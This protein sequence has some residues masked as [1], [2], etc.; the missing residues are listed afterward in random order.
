MADA[1]VIIKA[2]LK[3]EDLTRKI[4]K[5]VQDV[6]N[7]FKD[8]ANKVDASI[9]KVANSLGNFKTIAQTNVREIKDAFQQLGTTFDQFARAMERAAAAASGAGRGRGG[10]GGS[11]GTGVAAPNF[12]NAETLGELKQLIRE[13]QKYIDTLKLGTDE[14]KSQLEVLRKQQEVVKKASSTRLENRNRAIN[15]QLGDINSI[16]P[17]DVSQAESKLQRLKT[18]LGNMERA[19][20]RLGMRKFDFLP[21]STWNRI[22][23]SITRTERQL[24][25]LQDQAAKPIMPKDM[26]GVMGMS[27]KTL[28]QIALKMKAITQLRAQTP[29]GSADISRLNAEYARLSKLQTEIIGKNATLVES[30]NALGRAF[31]YIKNRLAFMLTVGAFTGFVRQLYEIRGQYELL[32]R[33]LGVLLNSFSKGSQIF[34]ELNEMAIKSPFTLIELGTA[35]KQLTAYNFKAN[36]VVD[37]TRR[38]ADISSALGVPM[39]RLV[40]NLGQI[41]AQTVLTARDAR[42][43]ANAGLAIVP[44]LAKHYTE[45]EGKVVSTA[46]VFDRMKKKAVSYNDVMSVLY[47]VTD[48]GGKFFDFQAKQAGTLKVQLANLNLAWNNMLNDMGKANQSLLSWPVQGLRDMFLHWKDISTAIEI[49]LKGLAAY[50]IAQFAIT[51]L[52]GTTNTAMVFSAQA[53]ARANVT[54]LRR[55][56]LTRQLTNEEQIEL[57]RNKLLMSSKKAMTQ[58]DYENVLA[59][60]KLSKAQATQL[61]TTQKTNM[62]LKEAL[63][64]TGTLTR[65]ELNN[66]AVTN[67]WSLAWNRLTITIANVARTIKS[68][69]FNIPTLIMSALAIGLEIKATFNEASDAIEEFNKDLAT[70]AKESNES[71]S[72]FLNDYQKTNDSLYKWQGEGTDRTQIGKQ[73]IATDE[74]KKAWEAIKEEIIK[75]SSAGREFVSQLELIAD[76]NERVRQGFKYIQEIQKVHG[77][78]QDVDKEAIKVQQD[79][80]K[81]WNLWLA[82]DSMVENIKDYVKSVKELEENWGGVIKALDDYNSKTNFKGGGYVENYIHDITQLRQNLSETA[83]DMVRIFTEKGFSP[84][85][86]REAFNKVADE[87]V[88]KSNL[89]TEESLRFRMTLEEQYSAERLK[90]YKNELGEN[91][92]AAYGNWIETFETGQSLESQF[93]SWLGRNYRSE[94]QQMFGNMTEEEIKQI[95]WSEPKWAEW[96]NK[97]ANEFAKQFGLSFNELQSL[98]IMANRWSVRIPVFFDFQ[99]TEKTLLQTLTDADAK[100]D[101][102]QTAIDRLNRRIKDG[103][104]DIDERAKADKELAD[105]EK[106]LAEAEAEGGH[107]KKKDQADKKAQ[108]AANKA[109]KAR[110]RGQKKSEDAVASALRSEISVIKEMQS[111]YDKLRKSGVSSTESLEIASSGYNKTLKSINATLSKYGISPF[112][113]ENFVGSSDPHKLLTALQNQLDTLIKSGKVKTASLKDLEMEIQKITVDAK[114]YDMKKITD[115]LNN[116]LGKIKEEYELAVELDANPELGGI[117]ADMMGIS[118]EEIENLPKDYAQVMRKLQRIIDEN[119]GSGA[120]NLSENLNKASFDQWVKERGNELDD[121]FAKALDDIREYAN[122]VRLDETKKITQD[123]D[124]LLEKYA[125]YEHKRVQIV[126]ETERELETARKHGASSDIIDAIIN[127]GKQG[128]AK[129]NFEEFQKSSIWITA[130]GDLSKLSNQALQILIDSLVEF[131][132]V[133]KDLDPKQ[134]QKINKA[135]RQMRKEQA[136]DNPF[137]A[138]SI[139]ML[140]ADERAE[141]IQMEM[142]E[143]KAKIDKMQAEEQDSTIINPE[144]QK[145]LQEMKKRLV[146]LGIL[147]EKVS[148]IPF[149]D[150][151]KAIGAYVKAFKAVADTFKQI[152]DSTNDFNM[153]QTADAISDVI[154]NFE[155]AEQGA[156]TWGGWW[157][158]IIGGV[159]DAIPKIMKWVSGNAQIDYD[160]QQSQ[161]QV[162]KLTNF[163]KEL[164]AAANKAYGVEAYGAQKAMLINKEFQLE[165]LKAQLRLEKSRKKKYQDQA[166]ISDLEGQI[167]DLKNEIN[168]ATE[169]IVNDLLGIT[170]KADF[171]ENLVS[172]MID[173][174]KNGEDYMKVFEESFE[175]MVD[176][177]IMKAIVSRLVGDWIN[178]IWDSVNA[179]VAQSDRVRE[180][181]KNLKEAESKLQGFE[182]L[183]NESP[184]Y[185]NLQ[186]RDMWRKKY[187]EA[188][189]AYNNAITPTPEDIATMREFFEQGRD[190]FKNNFLAYM[191]AFGIKFGQSAGAADLSALQQGIMGI[192]EDTASALEAYMNGVSQQVYLHS[193]LLTQ[194]RDILI[195]F[196]GDVTIATN[197]QILLQLQQSFQVQMTI[198]NVL[199]G[200]LNASGLAFRVELAN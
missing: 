193:D 48:E 106:A 72:K 59:K 128:L 154:G 149:A 131:K 69:F 167:I 126:K 187:E 86:E 28:D 20:T 145:I 148:K 22:Q 118:K 16:L 138:L 25:R 108:N 175:D 151:E 1:D 27:E 67:A 38:L 133:N 100:A 23:A 71:L 62:A 115:G 178:S 120:F 122:K 164:E 99:N 152:A 66:A 110:A 199:T 19:Y 35:A 64:S 130:T 5:L 47:K 155:A 95:N 197:A 161:I 171:A 73:D 163:Y 52:I 111:A 68:M 79:F 56:A 55:I 184:T 60:V 132:R 158:A 170:S 41:R 147:K 51:K 165:A 87:I 53:E 91:Y 77:A 26:T 198:Q 101:A 21:E 153:K 157:G 179:K 109:A 121:G 139:A 7:K 181:E 123:W 88:Q 137:K 195:N 10:V 42:D 49:A 89:S 74:A 57:A 140:E 159:T 117:F 162:K 185:T 156:Q 92:R 105:A 37:T 30:N 58:A 9:K 17:K 186:L 70:S 107:S 150:K 36:E 200:V 196:G 173:A 190:D 182:E 129:L 50:K 43:F 29:I 189:A 94:V 11:G 46:D 114:E 102:A 14:L 4:D 32:E 82:N 81:W 112:K 24:K 13:Q 135:L 63:V 85:Q 80:S 96:A 124:K 78:L 8:M 160:I 65:E 54:R 146:Q 15:N 136:K 134:I 127:K 90:L 44:E 83:A 119:I 33:S 104:T 116:E 84:E 113:A 125:E 97:N 191:D 93:L 61:V 39:E 45:L 75:S 76:V 103:I 166:T 2:D 180:A 194:I 192:T 168:D 6:D 188:L 143:L 34:N 174:F 183:A 12:D 40:Y 3:E 142:D 176:H 141:E 144:N 169:N 31:N 177:M 18:L 172:S 98:V